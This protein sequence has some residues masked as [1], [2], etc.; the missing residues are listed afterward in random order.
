MSL[1]K[2][3]RHTRTR[4]TSV[5][6]GMIV[7]GRRRSRAPT[8]VLLLAVASAALAAGCSRDPGPTTV[9]APAAPQASDASSTPASVDHT[10]TTPDSVDHTSTTPD[11]TTSGKDPTEPPRPATPRC[12]TADLALEVGQA[13]SGMGRTGLN[14]ALVNQSTHRCRI[15]GYGGVQLL[16]PAGAACTPCRSA[17]DHDPNWSRSGQETGP[18]RRSPGSTAQRR[19]PA[20]TRPSCRSSRRT[21]PSRSGP[22]SHPRSAGTACSASAPTSP[23]QPDRE[24]PVPYQW[25][26]WLGSNQRARLAADP[27]AARPHRPTPHSDASRRGWMHAHRHVSK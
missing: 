24:P 22:G 16:D 8:A 10:P 3:S 27:V 17:A 18:T 19:R 15:Y 6:S 21:R 1:N 5:H 23:T 4:T 7:A 14:L 12:H 26:P 11:S 9:S 20:R 2:L 13:D 25:R